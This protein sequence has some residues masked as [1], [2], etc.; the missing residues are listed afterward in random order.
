M[1]YLSS[2]KISRIKTGVT[3]A[4][5]V[6]SSILGGLES[7]TIKPLVEQAMPTLIELMCDASVIVRDTNAWTIGRIC[8]VI[9][10]VAI[11]PQF[12]EP[13]LQA[14]LNQL[15]EEPRVASNVCWAFTGLPQ[16][17]Y[18]AALMDEDEPESYCLSKYFEFV[19]QSLLQTT[20][21]PDGGQSNLRAV[22]D[23]N[24]QKFTERLLPNST[25]NDHGNPGEI[26]SKNLSNR[27]IQKVFGARFGSSH[28]SDGLPSGAE[29]L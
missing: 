27:R 17:A 4:L 16:A 19:V 7:Q 14:L 22:A 3:V 13:L 8:E 21:R 10:Q 26:E 12:L 11:D 2:R 29:G 25:A 15:K 9:P 5:M 6:F 20:D 24:D 1:F 23:G 28:S 18:D